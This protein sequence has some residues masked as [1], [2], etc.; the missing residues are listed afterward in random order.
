MGRRVA[1]PHRRP[2]LLDDLDAWDRRDLPREP[3][4]ACPPHPPTTVAAGSHWVAA[5]PGRSATPAPRVVERSR[6]RAPCRGRTCRT[7][8]LSQIPVLAHDGEASDHQPP[9][10]DRVG[11]VL[12]V[13]PT[14]Y[15]RP[16]ASSLSG[17]RMSSR[18]PACRRAARGAVRSSPGRCDH[19]RDPRRAAATAA[20]VSAASLT[21]PEP[22]GPGPRAAVRSG[23]STRVLGALR[24]LT[25][26]LLM[27][28]ELPFGRPERQ[29]HRFSSAP[30]PRT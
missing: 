24:E 15:S 28:R 20:A 4:A 1:A 27:H 2:R 23:S 22:P 9:L 19:D 13:D 10:G 16:A 18:P 11:V 12:A 30:E 7:R 6:S 8:S 25:H 17:T 3:R 14:V 26:Q 29:R 21:V 5:E